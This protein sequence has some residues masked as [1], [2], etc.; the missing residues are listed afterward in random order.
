M[1]IRSLVA[2]ITPDISLAL[3]YLELQGVVLRRYLTQRCAVQALER[4]LMS[5]PH[6]RVVEDQSFIH[7]NRGS[8][9]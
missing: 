9:P 8:E 4:R 5:S 7:Q 2:G 6:K 1:S 3:V